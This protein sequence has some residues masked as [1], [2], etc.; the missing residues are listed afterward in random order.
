MANGCG[1]IGMAHAFPTSSSGAVFAAV[2]GVKFI[3]ESMSRY[4]HRLSNIEECI[5]VSV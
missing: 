5:N 3:R 1:L 2:I 4:F